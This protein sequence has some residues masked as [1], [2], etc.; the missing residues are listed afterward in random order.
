LLF[1]EADPVEI[2]EL[3]YQFSVE[4]N[5]VNESIQPDIPTPLMREYVFASTACALTRIYD[6]SAGD[7]L[8]EISLDDLSI[9]SQ[10]EIKDLVTRSNATTWCEL[11]A[12]LRAE[13]Y[14]FTSK[15]GIKAIVKGS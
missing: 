5:D 10:R 9:H 3:I 1:P 2:I 14:R 15:S 6:P 13:L 4:A 7:I 8:S 11:A 12:V